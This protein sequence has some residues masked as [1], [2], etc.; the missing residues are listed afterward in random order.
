VSYVVL[1]HIRPRPGR[2][3]A[4]YQRTFEHML[5]LVSGMDGFHSVEGFSGEDGSELA[6]AKFS[7]DDAIRAWKAQPEHVATQ[8][9]GR[10][11]FFN[12]YQVTIAAVTRSY[13][14]AAPAGEPFGSPP[15]RV[16]APT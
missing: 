8:Q 9:R 14:W 12:S 13:E 7:T 10:E 16:G 2:D 4:E 3:E 5:K 15:S 11:E 6:V 1:F